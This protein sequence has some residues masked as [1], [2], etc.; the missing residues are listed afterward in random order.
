MLS[1]LRPE[2]RDD[3]ESLAYILSYL[4]KGGRLFPKRPENIKKTYYFDEKLNLIP[5]IFLSDECCSPELI[6]FFNYI[7]YLEPKSA[8]NYSYLE[9]LF[10]NLLPKLEKSTAPLNELKYD[11]VVQMESEN[12]FKKII[13]L[14]MYS[15]MHIFYIILY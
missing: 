8:I 6:S 5:E 11:W 13:C 4:Y 10:T 2:P 7:R 3:L 14:A 12:S 1:G 15:C 9:G